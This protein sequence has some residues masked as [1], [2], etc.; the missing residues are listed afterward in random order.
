MTES[1]AAPADVSNIELA[2]D[3]EEDDEWERARPEARRTPDASVTAQQDS[4]FYLG[5]LL[6]PR[7]V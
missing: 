1:S 7:L 5:S 4:V 2:E 6:P 3:A